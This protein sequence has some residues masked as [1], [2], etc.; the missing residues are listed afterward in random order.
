MAKKVTEQDAVDALISAAEDTIPRLGTRKFCVAWMQAGENTTNW[1]DFLKEFRMYA[2]DPYYPE[3]L[4]KARIWKYE[5]Q[6]STV[7]GVHPPK[8]PKERT[9]V[10]VMF[11][12]NPEAERERLRKDHPLLAHLAE[13]SD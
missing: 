7:R 11:F 12:K 5:K 4:I 10:A 6:M 13:Q 2:G 9:P 1:E 3:H 8:Y